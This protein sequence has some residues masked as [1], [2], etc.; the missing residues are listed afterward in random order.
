MVR[1]QRRAPAALRG[2][3]GGPG[4]GGVRSVEGTRS[5]GRRITAQPH[6]AVANRASSRGAGAGEVRVRVVR[7]AAWRL[8]LEVCRRRAA[9]RA[10]ASANP[11]C[12]SANLARVSVP[13]RGVGTLK[14]PPTRGQ[15]APGS[16]RTIAHTRDRE[17]SKHVSG[18]ARA[19]ATWLQ[20]MPLES[21]GAMCCSA[22]CVHGVRRGGTKRALSAARPRGAR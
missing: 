3:D 9:R 12:P 11:L 7:R 16:A 14:N 17:R 6:L 13:Q 1:T 8:A 5:R 22:G 21:C 2:A 20:H 4:R 19:T 10:A 18:F 15:R